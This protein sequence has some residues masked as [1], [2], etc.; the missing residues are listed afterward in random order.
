MVTVESGVKVFKRLFSS[1]A[2]VAGNISTFLVGAL[3]LCEI[4]FEM[5]LVPVPGPVRGPS[6]ARPGPVRA[7]ARA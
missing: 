5:A 6:G 4:Y 2:H 3:H 1:R 7:P